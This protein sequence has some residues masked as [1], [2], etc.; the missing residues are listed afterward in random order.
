MSTLATFE[1]TLAA[2]LAVAVALTAL[3]RQDNEIAAGRARRSGEACLL[4]LLLGLA[5]FALSTVGLESHAVRPVAV[6]AGAA[7]LVGTSSIVMLLIRMLRV[8]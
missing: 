6:G 5:S 1:G 4:L 7:L 3:D 8:R 2:I